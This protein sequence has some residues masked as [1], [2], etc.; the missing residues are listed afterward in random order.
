MVIMPDIKKKLSGNFAVIL[1][2]AAALVVL[3]VS[4]Y[5]GFLVNSISKYLEESI[6]ERILSASRALTHLVTEEELG[7]LLVP[8]DIEKPLFRDIR[9]RLFAFGDEHRVLY[10]YY[11][12]INDQ[13]EIQY[14]ADNDPDNRTDVN[15]ASP[16]EPVA[17][18]EILQVF[19]EGRAVVT[20]V[21]QYTT[22]Y[23]GLI[24]A[25]APMFNR[26]G[27]II[28]LAGIDIPDDQL[29]L[30]RNNSR[31][32]SVI[33][34]ISIIFIIV[35]GFI[36]FFVYNK[37]EAAFERRFKQ[38]E[39]MSELARS[40]ISARDTSS[41]INDALK[42]TG[43]FM[44]AT[45]LLIGIA[46]TDSA[47]SDAAYVWCA[48]SNIA[49]APVT[50]GLDDIINSFPLIQPQFGDIPIICCNDVRQ[51]KRYSVMESVKVKSFIMAPLYVDGKF[52]AVMSIEEC[53]QYRTWTDSDRQLVNAVS[54]V[55][56]GAAIRDLRERERNAAL[57][58]AE[59]ASRAKGDFLANMSHEMRTPMNA[60]IGM[61]AIGK[62]APDIEKKEYCLGKIEEASAHLLGV[63]NDILD[64]SKIE[65]NKFELSIME[66]NFE[67]MIQKASSVINFR[68]EEKHQTFTITID[69]D[70][71]PV[72]IG[73][74]LRFSQVITNLLSNAVKF[75]PEHGTIELEAVLE[76]NGAKGSTDS[77]DSSGACTIRVSVTD[78]GIGISPEQQARLFSSFQQA[79]SSTSRKFGGTGLGLA[80]SKRIVEMMKGFIWVESE[81]GKGSV[82]TFTAPLK[83]G[84]GSLDSPGT[85]QDGAG[86]N[87]GAAANDQAAPADN[88][89]GY[90]ILLVEDVEINREIVLSLL[91]PTKI[92]VECAENG[93]LAVRIFNASPDAF[94]MIFMDIQMPE[95]DGY[96]ATRAI[97]ASP[98]PNA[99]TIP[100]IAMTANVFKE[101]VEKC[102]AAGMNGHVG[103]PLNLEDVLIQLRKYLPIK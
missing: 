85:A 17:E 102:L 101:D 56:A 39:L 24:T 66:F 34:L 1:F 55:I 53:L 59:K 43:E 52:W 63:I 77:P 28:A 18:P 93:D 90:R 95:M 67:K 12:R 46:E 76:E 6:E 84:K 89:A 29:L 7:E 36:S 14:I 10:A 38:Q 71:P 68:V 44:G 20:G 79:D 42:I 86:E 78:S 99:K 91:E 73:D 26:A 100:I 45:R 88:F 5:T 83:I 31:V 50:E 15:L 87:S 3:F 11:F 72:L 82:F 22:G 54:S 21:G 62:A 37:K 97:R 48:D 40:F 33:L 32:L 25:Y 98:A 27:E 30:A 16:P 96:E 57:E 2:S 69:K 64:M 80:I 19:T 41:L 23:E 35:E 94:N 51:D 8:G 49:A 61:T 4:I 103:K 92:S 58:Q 65:A 47:S 74:D 70:I 60:I 13:G 75:T 9:N 81:P